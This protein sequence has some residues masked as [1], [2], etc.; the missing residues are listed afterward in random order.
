MAKID[1]IEF[2]AIF[3]GLTR[4]QL[5]QICAITKEQTCT[6]G[7][8]IFEENSPS[9]EFYIIAEGTIDIQIDPDLIRLGDDYEPGTIA[10]LHQGQA[11]GEISLVDEGARSASAKC[12]ADSARL[13]VIDCGDFMDLMR[14]DLEMGFKVMNNLAAELSLKIRQTNLIVRESLIYTPSSKDD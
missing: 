1:D 12:T 8:V 4:Q 14:S 6:K 13:I 9:K 5:E 2:V 7:D 11:F 3:S 10:R